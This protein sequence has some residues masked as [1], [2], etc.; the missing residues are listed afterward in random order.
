MRCG[1]GLVSLGIAKGLHKI[2]E[3]MV[4]EPMTIPL[5]EKEP[6]YLSENCFSQIQTILKDKQALAIGPGIG[7][8]QSTKKL[9]QKLVEQSKIPLILDA[10]ALNCIADQPEILKNKKTVTILTPHPGEMARLCNMSTFKIQNNRLQI[11][12]NF[13]KEYNCIVILKGA[14]TIVSFPDGQSKINPTGNPGMAS[15]GMGDVLTGMIAGFCAQG[16]SPENASLAA[17]FI[18]GMCA[19]ILA[20]NIGNFGFLASDMVKI[21]PEAIHKYLL[22]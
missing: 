15:G 6:G 10:D 5:L 13:A 11:A 14:Q 21:I 12:S 20:Q 7:T 2:I 22:E 1:T 16:F 19:D 9:V 18:H 4:I 8:R 3:P 17:V